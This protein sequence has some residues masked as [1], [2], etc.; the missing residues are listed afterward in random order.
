MK[1]ITLPRGIGQ[2][3]KLGFGCA[4]LAGGYEARANRKL[5]NLAYDR[6]L[7]H[8][9]VAPL[10]GLGHAEDVLG[11]ALQGRRHTV[12]IATKFGIARPR[13]INVFRSVA[14]LLSGPIRGALRR[15]R[16][17][18]APS[19]KV[20]AAETD[21]SSDLLDIALDDSLRRLRT[22]YV[23]L[24]LLHEVRSDT[25]HD[26]LITALER[27]RQAGACRSLGL[28]TDAA[29]AKQ[30]MT[31]YPGI[32]DVLQYSWS[33]LDQEQPL[34]SAPLVI[35][36]RAVRRALAP[37]QRWLLNDQEARLRLEQA[38]SVNLSNTTI[39]S[40]L[41]IGAAL[42]ANDQGIVLVASHDPARIVQNASVVNDSGIIAAGVRLSAALAL[43]PHRPRPT[44]G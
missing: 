34:L 31:M 21:F 10:Y 16:A 4:Y 3:T 9:D 20:P 37:L 19:N 40:R 33:V 13:P 35:T 42:A 39:L 17:R 8:F 28:A 44:E 41:L 43:E 2:T 23:D 18:R 24:L 36:H 30:I 32:F 5:V 14:R 12:S 1:W 7:R 38:T 11:D 26:G 25:I 22:D 15:A 6:G 27:R 29:S